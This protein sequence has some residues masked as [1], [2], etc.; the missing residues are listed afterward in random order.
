M[1][2]NNSEALSNEYL[3]VNSCGCENLYG[4]DIGS[5]RPDGRIDYHILYIAEGCCYVTENNKEKPAYAGS[6]IVY[7]PKERQEYKFYSGTKSTSYFIHFSGSAC[8]ELFEKFN[9]TGKRIFHIGKS[10]HIEN[11]FNQLIDEFNLKLPFYEYSCQSYLLIILSVISRQISFPKSRAELRSK[12]KIEKTCRYMYANYSKN[13]AITEYAKMCN[14]SESRF[15]HIFKEYTGYSPVQ[16]LLNIK[17]KRA[18]ELLEYTDLSI[19]QISDML[20]MQSQ[21]Y[22]SRIFKNHTKTSPT[23][24]RK[25]Q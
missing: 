7:L 2:K 6:V 10:T 25:L 20:G 15:S 22:F 23:E 3:H 14:L 1:K 4:R 11:T 17:I 16:Y 12:E 8:S 24:Y 21:N 5:L 9:L 19:L 13:I 18:K